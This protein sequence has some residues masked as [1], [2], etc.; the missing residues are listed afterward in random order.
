MAT[1][2][3]FPIVTGKSTTAI[4]VDATTSGPIRIPSWAPDI[5]SMSTTT[6]HG[7]SFGW[8]ATTALGAPSKFNP[9]SVYT[10]R[11]FNMKTGARMAAGDEITIIY[12]AV[13]E[14][15]RT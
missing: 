3:T 10:K 1:Q 2:I 15:V 13:G 8:Y 6:I 14:L 4:A 11:S 9:G 5:A 12:N 7:Q